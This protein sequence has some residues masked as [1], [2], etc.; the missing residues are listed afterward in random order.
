M[1]NRIKGLLILLIALTAFFVGSWI[2]LD[3]TSPVILVFFGIA[4]PPLSLGLL[5]ISV[6]AAGVLLGLLSGSVVSSL[7]SLKLR[8]VTRLYENARQTDGE[9][10]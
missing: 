8:R 7:L 6:F 3:N 2:Y 9:K 1:L 5:V 4:L 10:K